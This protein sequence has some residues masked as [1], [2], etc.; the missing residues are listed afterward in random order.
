MLQAFRRGLLKPEHTYGIASAIR[1]RITL[2]TL[3]MEDNSDYVWRSLLVKNIIVAPHLDPKKLSTPINNA[4][5]ELQYIAAGYRFNVLEQC[6]P[7]ERLTKGTASLRML[8]DRMKKS[9]IIDAFAKR[10][11]EL[12]KKNI[13]DE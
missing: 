7:E 10:I 8:F 13:K 5:Q 12:K 11:E 6:D 2:S 3:S 4:S 9:G 1:E